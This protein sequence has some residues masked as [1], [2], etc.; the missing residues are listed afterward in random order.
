[1]R[2]ILIF[3]MIFGSLPAILW[4]PYFGV[5]VWSWLAYMNPHRLTWG[6]AYD[7]RFS[8]IVGA[9][10]VIAIL[11]SSERKRMLWTAV[12]VVWLAFFFWTWLTTQFALLPVDAG[13]EWSR[14]WKIN[15][16]S[17]LTLLVMQNRERVH[18]LVWVIVVSLGFY[19]IKGGVFAI[20]TGGQY[21]VFGPD[22]SFIMDNTALGLALIM[23]LPLMRYLQLEAEQRWLKL[24]LGIGMALMCVAILSTQ[25]RGAFLGLAAMGVYFVM[26]SPNRKWAILAAVL[27]APALYTFMPQSWHDR[28]A[29][30]QNYEQDG[31]AMGRINAWGFA[32]NLAKDRP[33]VGGGFRVF[34]REFFQIWAPDPESFADSHS[35]YFEVLGEQG[36]VGLALFLLL[37]VVV[38]LCARRVI[39]RARGDPQLT[40]ARNLAAM[41]QVS[42]V[43]YAVS[44]AFLGLAYFDLVYQLIAILVIVDVL[45]REH[46]MAPDPYAVPSA[47]RFGDERGGT[48]SDDGLQPGTTAHS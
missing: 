16:M 34:D 30:I 15:L 22:R 8:V 38:M 44:G 45:V 12:T 28:M 46:Q 27:L 41:I 21:M 32:Y 37:G 20:L 48:P 10:L 23:T 3:A 4:R 40:W 29:T 31:S 35:I 26:K 33:I 36:F 47:D 14:W 5:L 7:F 25:S 2:D 43:G 13:E 24:G 1:M 18:L 17:L 42:L 6:A 19:G 9:T 11:F 39:R